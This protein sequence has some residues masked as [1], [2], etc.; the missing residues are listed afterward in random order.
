[1]ELHA[2]IKGMLR[3]LYRLH[4]PPVRRQAADAH[5]R[6][7]ERGAVVVVELEAVAVPL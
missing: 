3:Q 2:H 7:L 6:R 4:Q 5:A 1:M